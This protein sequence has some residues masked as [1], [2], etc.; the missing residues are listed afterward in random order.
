[1]TLEGLT[2]RDIRSC[3]AHNKRRVKEGKDDGGPD[4][5]MT[6]K[7]YVELWPDGDVVFHGAIICNIYKEQP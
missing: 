1:M 5:V 4:V 6:S 7:G 2:S 3:L